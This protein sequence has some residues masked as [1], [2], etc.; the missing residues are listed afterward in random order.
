MAPV[1]KL[2]STFPDE[3]AES[4]AR[5]AMTEGTVGAGTC[6]MTELRQEKRTS[7][8]FVVL[9]YLMRLL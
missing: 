7:G 9:Q 5:M 8:S 1:G 2:I 3:W 4:R 6:C